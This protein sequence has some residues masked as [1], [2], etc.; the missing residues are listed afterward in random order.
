MKKLL[1]FFSVGSLILLD[2]CKDDDS[3]CTKEVPATAIDLVDKTR[4]ESDIATINDYLSANNISAQS[5]PYGVR[6]VITEQG[7]GPT[8]CLESFVTVKYKGTLMKTGSQFDSNSTGVTFKLNGLILGWQL[9][10][11]MIQ[12]GSKVTL[13]IPSGFGYGPEG[14]GGGTIPSNAN[15]I[16]ELELTNVR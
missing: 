6:Y 12:A 2:A 5:E 14:G 15:L 11:P 10:L 1:L 9:V 4:L 16:F 7:T 3:T 13:Y 8:P